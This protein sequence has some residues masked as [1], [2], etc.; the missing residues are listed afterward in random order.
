MS[1]FL[2]RAFVDF[3]LAFKR[4]LRDS[5]RWHQAVWEA[6]P[7]RPE[8]KREFLTRLDVK[9]R[10]FQL[11]LLSASEPSKPD[12]APTDH[13]ETKPIDAAFFNHERYSFQLRANPTKKLRVTLPDGS[14]KKNGRR[15]PLTAREELEQWI[16]RKADGGGFAIDPAQVRIHPARK[17]TFVKQEESAGRLLGVIQGMEFRGTLEVRDRGKFIQAFGTGIGPAKAF[18]YGMLALAPVNR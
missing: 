12:W 6:F 17:E 4:G 7:G 14:R 2:T 3:E 15:Q 10:G 9:D 11:L 8:E 18:G 13:W 1:L 5:Y 16:A